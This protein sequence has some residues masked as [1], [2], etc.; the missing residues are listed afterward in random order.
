M[1]DFVTGRVKR[2]SGPLVEVTGLA[3]VAM[4]DIVWVGGD[5]LPG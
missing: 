2:V 3:K 4:S 5:R 1:S